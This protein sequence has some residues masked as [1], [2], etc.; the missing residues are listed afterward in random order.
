VISDVIGSLSIVLMTYRLAFRMLTGKT[1]N[2]SANAWYAEPLEPP[3][4]VVISE[5]IETLSTLVTTRRCGMPHVELKPGLRFA[6]PRGV[7]QV[8]RL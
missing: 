8:G 6:L 2:W 7:S 3:K 4:Q 1:Q 5:V